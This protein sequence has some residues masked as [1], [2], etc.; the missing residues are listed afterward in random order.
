MKKWFFILFIL[1]NTISSF[2][3]I[4]SNTIFHLGR[5]PEGRA[6]LDDYLQTF[7][8]STLALSIND[9]STLYSDNIFHSNSSSHSFSDA[10]RSVTWG[11]LILRNE[12][13]IN[14]TGFF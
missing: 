14:R 5:I 13:S 2:S 7:D 8:D 10:D 4:S 12:N 3:Q 9:I 6:V 11:R 1:L